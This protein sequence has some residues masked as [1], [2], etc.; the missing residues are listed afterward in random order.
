MKKLAVLFGLLLAVPLFAVPY[1]D[2]PPQV[3]VGIAVGG[4]LHVEVSF[5]DMANTQGCNVNSAFVVDPILDR[6]T[7][8]AMLSILLIAKELGLPVRVRLQGCTDRP[9][10]NY[11][12]LA[13]DWL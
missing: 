4:G 1:Q 11:V 8:E 7:K 2:T 3:P 9:K 13:V 12:F 5:P 6:E 10:F